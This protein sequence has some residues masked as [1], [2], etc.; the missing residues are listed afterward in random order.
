MTHP[1]PGRPL[2]GTVALVAGATRGAG[3]AIAVELARPSE[4]VVLG[5]G[6][7]GPVGQRLAHGAAMDAVAA[8]QLP[9]RQPLPLAVTPISTGLDNGGSRVEPGRCL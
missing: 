6:G 1:H 3:R 4:L 9:E 5:G 8:R 7:L 2:S